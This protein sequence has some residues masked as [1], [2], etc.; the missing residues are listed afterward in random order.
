[1]HG[2]RPSRQYCKVCD[3]RDFDDQRLLAQLREIVGPGVAAGDEIHRKYW[4]F[5][6]L[7]MYLHDAGALHERTEVLATA[8]GSDASLFWLANRV[9]RV[10]ATDIYGEGSFAHREAHTTML[11]NPAAFAPYPYNA[12]RLEVRAMNRST[13]SSQT[14]HS[15]WSTRCRQSSISAGPLRPRAQLARWGACCAPVDTWSS[16]RNACLTATARRPARKLRDPGPD[17]WHPLRNRDPA[18]PCA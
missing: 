1:M 6:M 13:S 3:R 9:G 16:S 17:A 12:D 7:G 18:P 10:V 4:E 15:T 14:S 11:T 8:A 5:A 2:A